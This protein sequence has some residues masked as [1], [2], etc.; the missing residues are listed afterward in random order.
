ML[1]HTFPSKMP[2]NFHYIHQMDNYLILH[3]KFLIMINI[4]LT[5]PDVEEILHELTLSYHPSIYSGFYGKICFNNCFCPSKNIIKQ[6][7]SSLVS[8]IYTHKY[9]VNLK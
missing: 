3:R 2:Q 7:L 9:T 1:L 4:P 5:L 6:F 8:Y